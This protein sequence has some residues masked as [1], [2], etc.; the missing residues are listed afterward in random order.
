MSTATIQIRKDARAALRESAGRVAAAVQGAGE[1]G[2]ATFTFSSAE[3]LFRA[4]SPKRWALLEGLQALGPSSLRGLARSLG[5][6]VKR[7]HDDVAALIDLGL[8]ER[9]DAGQIRVPFDTIRVDCRL[10]VHAA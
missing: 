9:D 6:D 7:V 4:L 10:G 8:I 5:R 3:Q 1:S 2:G